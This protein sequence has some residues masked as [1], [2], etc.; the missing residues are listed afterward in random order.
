MISECI[1][2]IADLA[3]TPA[4]DEGLRALDLPRP[5]STTVLAPAPARRTLTEDPALPLNS[6]CTREAATDTE[7]VRVDVRI[8]T[9]KIVTHRAK[10][11]TEFPPCLLPPEDSCSYEP[12]HLKMIIVRMLL[13]PLRTHLLDEVAQGTPGLGVPRGNQVTH[14]ELRVRL[15][16]L[17]DKQATQPI[18]VTFTASLT[19]IPCGRT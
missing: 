1:Y 16:G 10:D 19:L 9:A 11:W 3:H 5:T 4:R 7:R 6:F 2:T 14:A 12:S 17:S 18:E 15:L 8:Q 13:S